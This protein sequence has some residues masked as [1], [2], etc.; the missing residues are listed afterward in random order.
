MNKNDVIGEAIATIPDWLAFL[1]IKEAEQQAILA[2]IT[3]A[4]ETAA[5][6]ASVVETKPLPIENSAVTP[7]AWLD[8]DAP[9]P[10]GEPQ[11]PLAPA[12]A[13]SVP[14]AVESENDDDDAEEIPPWSE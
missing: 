14:E 2:E 5:T 1:E 12:T 10:K 6:D 8:E 7:L 4:G 11:Q 9:P 3:Q 13:V